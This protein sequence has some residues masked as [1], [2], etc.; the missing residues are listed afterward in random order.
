[1]FFPATLFMH[2]DVQAGLKMKCTD[3]EA[4]NDWRLFHGGPW[5]QRLYSLGCESP[6]T[7]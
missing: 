4:A 5:L 3:P 6:K 1:M 2:G 7:S